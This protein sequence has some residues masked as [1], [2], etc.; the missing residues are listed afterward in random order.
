MRYGLDRAGSG[1]GPVAVTFEGGNE[2]SGSIKCE[3]FL[4]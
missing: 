1:Y 2:R 4:D 3:E